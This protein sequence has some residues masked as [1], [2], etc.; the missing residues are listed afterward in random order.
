MATADAILGAR[1]LPGITDSARLA[2]FSPSDA[3]HSE[4]DRQSS[5][6]RDARDT[7]R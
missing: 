7:P 1:H 3:R 2:T 6:L 5:R 4:P